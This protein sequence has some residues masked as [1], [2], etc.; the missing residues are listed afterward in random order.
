MKIFS[1]KVILPIVV[2]LIVVAII[3]YFVAPPRLYKKSVEGLR[4][5]A[6]LTVKSVDI[7][8]FRIAYAE[9]G[10]GETIIMLHG[11]SANKDYWLRFAKT[12]TTG[13][14]VIIPDLPGFGDSSKPM[15][16]KYNILAQVERLN[17]L[18][19]ALKLSQFHLVGNSMGGN[20]AGHYAAAYPDKVKTLA[21]FDASGVTVPVKS[22]RDLLIEKGINPYFPRNMNEYDKLFELNFYHPP[23]YPWFIK[24]YMAREAAKAAPMNE[25]IYKDVRADYATLQSNLNRITV[26]SLI[27]WGDSDRSIHISA[28][29]IFAGNIRKSRTAVIR[30]CGHLPMLEKPGETA[31]VYLEFL[32]SRQAMP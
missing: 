5:D 26:P 28:M 31:V 19:T 14:H 3:L 32:R 1:K 22:E 12:F 21:L 20:I 17:R 10:T 24:R 11:F 27:V 6:G 4:K 13:Y 8:D 16:A 18:A 9:G 25:K 23:A 15:Q 29:E 7:P 2:L 30:N